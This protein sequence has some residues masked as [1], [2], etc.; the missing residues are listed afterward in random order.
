MPRWW[1]GGW[2]GEEE[3]LWASAMGNVHGRCSHLVVFRLL[4]RDAEGGLATRRKPGA[5]CLVGRL[6]GFPSRPL[7]EA[8]DFPPTSLVE[9]KTKGM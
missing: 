7:S 6:P 8:H 5:R 4:E 9:C 1:R 2:G 3:G